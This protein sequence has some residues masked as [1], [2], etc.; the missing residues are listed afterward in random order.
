VYRSQEQLLFARR[1]QSLI[2]AA[3]KKIEKILGQESVS[4]FQRNRCDRDCIFSARGDFYSS[5]DFILLVIL[6]SW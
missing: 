4:L 1:I 2:T 6:F 3:L 5:G